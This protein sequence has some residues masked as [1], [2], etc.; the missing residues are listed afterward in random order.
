MMTAYAS[1]EKRQQDE[2]IKIDDPAKWIQNKMFLV[3]AGST[4]VG[5]L[6][7]V[8][9]CIAIYVY[10]KRRRNSVEDEDEEKDDINTVFKSVP[11]NSMAARKP[12]GGSMLIE[13]R[14]SHVSEESSGNGFPSFQNQK[15]GGANPTYSTVFRDSFISGSVNES[16]NDSIQNNGSVIPPPYNRIILNRTYMITS[17]YAATEFDEMSVK[18]GDV[19]IIHKVYEDGWVLC[20]NHENKNQGVI[21]SDCFNF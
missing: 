21:P 7:I 2:D 14:A 6:V 3:I 10:R 4:C 11:E 17:T 8:G 20:M 13:T 12:R 15:K 18:P 9:P 1:I 5:L 19:I 16:L